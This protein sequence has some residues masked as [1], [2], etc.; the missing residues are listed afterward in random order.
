M[1]ALT[2][3]KKTD[4]QTYIR[5]KS[6]QDSVRYQQKTEPDFVGSGYHP[7]ERFVPL[8]AKFSHPANA[9]QRTQLFNQLQRHYGNRYVQRVVSAYRS[10]NAEEEES[11]LAS[12]I[13]SRKGSGRALEPG[14]L[15]FQRLFK[16]GAIQAKLKIGQPNDIYEQEAD[17]AAEEV[18]RMPEPQI[19]R[20]AEEEEE[21]K[22]EEELIQT[23][24][25]SEQITPL[26]Q[27]QVEE[28]EEEKEEEEIFQTKEVLGQTPEVTPDLESRINAMRGR[29]EPLPESIRNFF[30]PRFGCDFSQVNV[31]SN[32]EA[33]Q[34]SRELNAEA[35]THGR[36]IYFG[37]GRYSPGTSSG[38][39]L[40]AHELTHVV[41]QGHG[42]PQD[43]LQRTIGDGHDL[44]SPRFAGDLVL[45]AVYD[46]ERL[47]TIGSRGEA[48]AKVQQALVDAGFP[49]PQYGVDDIFGSE[50]RRSVV[51]FQATAGLTVDGI[52]GPETMS[53]LDQLPICTEE[54][55][56][57][58]E[59]SMFAS[60]SSPRAGAGICYAKQGGG[61]GG[62]GGQLCNVQKLCNRKPL[63]GLVH[64]WGATFAVCSI[65]THRFNDG[66]PGVGPYPSKKQLFFDTGDTGPTWDIE[67]VHDACVPNS[68][69]D[70][71]LSIGFIQTVENLTW[72]AKYTVGWS[73][74]R[75]VPVRA[76]DAQPKTTPPPWINPAGA[77]SGP[78][79][80]GTTAPV[81]K[82][83][84]LV[85]FPIVLPQNDPAV[86]PC[87]FIHRIECTGLFTI[88]LVV[89]MKDKDLAFLAN[90]TIRL[91]QIG[92]RNFKDKPVLMSSWKTKKGNGKHALASFSGG[93]GPSD[94]AVGRLVANDFIR[95]L[96]PFLGLPC[97]LKLPP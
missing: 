77:D 14:N 2:A 59:K 23:K 51:E 49:L 17:R 32:S 57:P 36:N 1:K 38:K 93:K 95:I 91:S 46:N 53:H 80:F 41:Q 63:F 22:K 89:Q 45:E 44:T 58:E 6:D 96:F 55:E 13:L 65:K 50:T 28:E 69:P 79:K 29:G 35:F 88:W 68:I 5:T 7:P 33:I 61:G 8:L 75:V 26:I 9:T 71:D 86:E 85:P 43:T 74:Q 82:D 62:G 21:K 4:G 66:A 40:L 84:P 90:T 10:Q 34:M 56:I 18:M 67:A 76:R 83:R 19:Q 92:E 11:K 64:K 15:T 39:R 25:I 48:V 72:D 70:D 42:L 12:E 78:V 30:E 87:A 54:Y 27:R 94:P 24:P 3:E 31:H 20:Q 97:P 60:M 73:A 81:I 16:S 47:L 37:A 52:V